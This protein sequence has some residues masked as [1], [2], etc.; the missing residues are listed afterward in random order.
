MKIKSGYVVGAFIPI[1]LLTE[2]FWIPVAGGYLRLIHLIA[3][4]IIL[5]FLQYFKIICLSPVFLFLVGLLCWNLLSSLMSDAPSAAL[6]S[7]LLL[8]ANSLVAIATALV[9]A[10]G[11][12]SMENVVSLFIFCLI[13]SSIWGFI[14]VISFS[15]AGASLALSELQAR[16]I[17]AGFAPAFRTEA[18]TLA[19]FFSTAFLLTFPAVFRL[20]KASTFNIYAILFAAGMMMSFTRTV[21][22]TLPIILLLV[23]FW[24]QITGAGRFLNLRSLNLAVALFGIILTYAMYSGSFNEYSTHKIANFFNIEEILNGN[25]SSLRIL[26]T[27]ALVD[28]L[29]GSMQGFLL[30]SGWGQIYFQFRDIEM[31][32]GGADI[33]VFS[34]YGGIIS[35]ILFFLLLATSLYTTAKMIRREKGNR[36]TLYY[37]GTLFALIG[38]IVTGVLN[39]SM[40]SPEY[41]IVIGMAVHSGYQYM[42]RAS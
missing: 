10:S 11:R 6:I 5:S 20:K 19:K 31:Q 1:A 25:S 40:N 16:Q 33:L 26:W 39:S 32:P 2:F 3:P 24:T 29:L 22:Y 7:Y 35:G 36:E 17:T 4:I 15:L 42:K 13:T 37:Q 23:Y 30:G 12:V 14:Q 27:L 38:L 41:W 18:N 28:S 8:L 21:L 34:A 9:L